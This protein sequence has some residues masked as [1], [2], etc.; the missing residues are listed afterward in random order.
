MPLGV[1]QPPAAVTAASMVGHSDVAATGTVVAMSKPALQP[2]AAVPAAATVGQVGI[3]A[4]ATLLAAVQPTQ[5]PLATRTAAVG[6]TAVA[7]AMP[8]RLPPSIYYSADV[9]EVILY[10]SLSSHL[11]TRPVL[12]NPV[13]ASS[14]LP[15][16][17]AQLV[18]W[19]L[20]PAM[21]GWV[22]NQ[23]LEPAALVAT[24]IIHMSCAAVVH[25]VAQWLARCTASGALLFTKSQL[26]M[27]H[28]LKD[29]QVR[30]ALE[31]VAAGH[32]ESGD[33]MAAGG[34]LQNGSQ[35]SADPATALKDA[36]GSLV[37]L[38][39]P[40][41]LQPAH[42]AH[43]TLHEDSAA[44][45]RDGK[46]LPLTPG[47]TE[48]FVA[49]GLLVDHAAMRQAQ[50]PAA[51]GIEQVNA[52]LP[53]PVMSAKENCYPSQA[54]QQQQCPVT[55]GSEQAYAALNLL[56]VHAARNAAAL[57]LAAASIGASRAPRTPA[58]QLAG[59]SGSV[60]F[61]HVPATVD[62]SP[63][64]AAVQGLPATPCPAATALTTTMAMSGHS[65]A[66]DLS[67]L[68][69]LGQLPEG[70]SRPT[71]QPAPASKPAGAQVMIPKEQ[72]PAAAIT[73]KVRCLKSCWI[74][75]KLDC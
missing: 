26:V 14:A 67:T 41:V 9:G 71:L 15:A 58:E 37:G 64:I 3:A 18:T 42:Q 17:Q 70:A 43:E 60:Q 29:D 20:S 5:Q 66:F 48:G 10:V 16:V 34:G 33:G 19:L 55:P 50:P 24:D 40:T 11:P 30:E 51:V 59:T 57:N 22:D 28:K 74:S 21:S 45:Q 38:I 23:G 61:Q 63:G 7:S 2:P 13:H 4:T 46:R 73:H 44:W 75:L 1:Q 8:A 53:T 49:L 68:C 32:E 62:L 27:L 6:M 72:G 39:P 47:S 36:V 35:P 56:L 65:S 52:P 25:L 54:L 69:A 31:E 12:W